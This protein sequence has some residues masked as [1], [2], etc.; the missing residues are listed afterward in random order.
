MLNELDKEL[1]R[2]GHRFVRCGRC[3][4]IVQEQKECGEDDCEHY[5]I[6]SGSVI[7]KSKPSQD[8]SDPCKQDKIFGIRILQEQREMQIPGTPKERQKDE[9]QGKGDYPEK[10]RAE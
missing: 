10:Q 9:R 6:H 3:A 8:H 1:E 2:R 4:D 5:P 7:P